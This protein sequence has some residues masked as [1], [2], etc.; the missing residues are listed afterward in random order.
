MFHP[1]VSLFPEQTTYEDTQFLNKLQLF[2]A[3]HRRR[4]C[5]H[6]GRGGCRGHRARCRRGYH[7]GC[8]GRYRCRRRRWRPHRELQQPLDEIGLLYTAAAARPVHVGR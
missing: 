4:R 6:R 1:E 7:C 5:G 3:H 8:G 2:R